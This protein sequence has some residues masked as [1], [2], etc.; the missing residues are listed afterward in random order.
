MARR[1][2]DWTLFFAILLMTSMGLIMVYSASSV[3]A[4]F[5]GGNP[6]AIFLRQLA[7]AVVSFLVMMWLKRQNYLLLKD[8]V[9]AF[10]PLGIVIALLPVAYFMDPRT[11]RWIRFG[12]MQLQPSEFAKPALLVFLAYFLTRRLPAINSRFT[13]VPVG[14]MLVVLAG[15]VLVADM[16][17]AIALLV[18]ALVLFLVAGLKLRYLAY[19]G[20]LASL[21]LVYGVWDKPYRLA[22]V[23][24][25]FDPQ[26]ELIDQFDTGKVIRTR[27]AN[28]HSTRDPGYQIQQAKIATG[29]GGVLGMG[30]MQGRQKLLY[31]PEAH[32]D[33]IFAIV[34]EELGLWGTTAMLGGFFV[35]FWRGMRLF[36]LSKNDFGKFLALG[37]SVSILVQALIN[38]SVVLGLGPAKGIP[39][40]LISYGGSSLLSTLISLGILLSIS[41]DAQWLESVS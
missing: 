25:F 19:A 3:P 38:I 2:T 1:L 15:I 4:V 31:L 17:T 28:S 26:Y 32:T 14:M 7:A 10:A 29:S 34:G 20:A 23:V 21:V 39:L 33:M 40:P 30:I 16:G 35:I 18:P 27:I 22:R 37:I 13:L 11:H 12:F 5:K 8:P 9:W 36:W 6:E 41:E 24:E